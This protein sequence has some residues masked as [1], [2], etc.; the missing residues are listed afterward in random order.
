MCLVGDSICC[1]QAVAVNCEGNG[2]I[3]TIVVAAGSGSRFGAAKQFLEL[4]GVSVLDRS[5]L[6]AARHSD[7]VVVVVPTSELGRLSGGLESGELAE[8]ARCRVVAGG[9]TRSGSVRNGLGEVP[10]DADV[11][12]V[13]DAA[14]PLASDLIFENVIAAVLGGA[15]AATP[16]IPVTDTI[17]Y[18]S[19]GVVDRDQIVAV[20]TP[21]AF[22][23][24]VLRRVH[25]ESPEAT[26]DTS[27]VSEAGGIVEL[28]S[29]EQRNLKLTTPYDLEM[30]ALHLSTQGES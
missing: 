1:C 2:E 27:L 25:Q 15:D 7:G 28:V 16:A 18:R 4:G 23:A 20:Q 14:R 12:L 11:V 21:Q 3:W 22:R 5:V 10:D 9:S 13:H 19:G 24:K 8:G 6:V 30:A 29:G 17:R 26:D